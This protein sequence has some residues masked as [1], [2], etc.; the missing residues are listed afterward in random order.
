M[1]HKEECHLV[2]YTNHSS[3]LATVLEINIKDP[4]SFCNHPDMLETT[5]EFCLKL[6][7]TFAPQECTK[8]HVTTVLLSGEIEAAEVIHR[9]IIFFTI[10][11]PEAAMRS[12][13]RSR[14]ATRK[15]TIGTCTDRWWVQDIL[16]ESKTTRMEG[17]CKAR[18]RMN[19][20][21]RALHTGIYQWFSSKSS[22][23]RIHAI[24]R[25]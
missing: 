22:V 19:G 3:N 8:A 7:S 18:W 10:Q 12:M 21:S 11:M 16:W 14:S 25:V 1:M 20:A 15:M 17:R 23:T 5:N 4:H 24:S 9:G 13:S 6:M 2:F